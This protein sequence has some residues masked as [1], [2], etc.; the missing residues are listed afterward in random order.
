MNHGY[1]STSPVQQRA[2][3][4]TIR[5][6]GAD[7]NAVVKPAQVMAHLDRRLFKVAVQQGEANLLA[8]KAG[9]ELVAVLVL[10]TLR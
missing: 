2:S 1:A 9:V 5:A 8:T 3:P 4:G 10:R 7:F 6:L